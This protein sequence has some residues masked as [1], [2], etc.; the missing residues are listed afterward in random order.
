MGFKT[1]EPEQRSFG[2]NPA[3]LLHSWSA[4]VRLSSFASLSSG[5][6]IAQKSWCTSG[7]GQYLPLGYAYICVCVNTS[8]KMCIYMYVLPIKILI[9]VHMYM[10]MYMDMYIYLYI[11]SPSLSAYMYIETDI[12]CVYIYT[13]MYIHVYTCPYVQLMHAY[14]FMDHVLVTGGARTRWLIFNSG[15][16]DMSAVSSA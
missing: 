12:S 6:R 9:H 2:P 13:Y 16:H 10:D 15:P 8:I 1:K 11:D 5:Q 3:L 7:L 14:K 4:S